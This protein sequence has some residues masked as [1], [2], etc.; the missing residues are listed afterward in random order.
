MKFCTQ[1][2]I[3]IWAVV[4][5]GLQ[6]S[7]SVILSPSQTNLVPGKPRSESRGQVKFSY[8]IIIMYSIYDGGPILA[9][10]RRIWYLHCRYF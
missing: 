8:S 3:S 5:S 2:D 9:H 1:A 10:N 6:Y 4:C 7:S